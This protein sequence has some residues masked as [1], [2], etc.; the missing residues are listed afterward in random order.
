[1]VWQ[2]N[3]LNESI[4]RVTGNA[5]CGRYV[6]QSL[7]VK[8]VDFDNW[9]TI[10]FGNARPFFNLYLVDQDRSRVAGVIVVQGS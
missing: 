10:N 9:L 2:F 4:G 6:F 8:A 1:M 5:K 7:M 3:G